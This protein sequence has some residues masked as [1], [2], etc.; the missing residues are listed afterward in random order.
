MAELAVQAKEAGDDSS[1]VA[2]KIRIDALKLD[3]CWSQAASA[4]RQFKKSQLAGSLGLKLDCASVI[5]TGV[6]INIVPPW[7]PVM[8]EVNKVYCFTKCEFIYCHGEEMT[9]MPKRT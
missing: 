4:D 9:D 1:N 6:I 3:I 7:L 8:S 2:D 5:I